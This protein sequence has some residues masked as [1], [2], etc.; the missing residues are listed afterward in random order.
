MGMIKGM[1]LTETQMRNLFVEAMNDT[2]REFIEM[3]QFVKVSC[4]RLECMCFTCTAHTTTYAAGCSSF[5][6]HSSHSW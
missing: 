4:R 1:D 5:P 6:V 2:G 3:E